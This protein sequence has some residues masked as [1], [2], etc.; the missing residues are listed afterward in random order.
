M[1]KETKNIINKHKKDFIKLIQYGDDEDKDIY[2][3][4][5]DYLV[6]I[7][8]QEETNEYNKRGKSK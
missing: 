6:K 5:A 7:I 1:T 8:Y 2:A 4:I 3:K